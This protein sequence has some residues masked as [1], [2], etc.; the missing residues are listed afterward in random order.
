VKSRQPET[1]GDDDAFALLVMAAAD[2][3]RFK[4]QLTAIL[5]LP[6]FHRRSL[7]NT[8]LQE[9]QMKQA[10]PALIRAVRFLLDDAVAAKALEILGETFGD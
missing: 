6:S 8:L 4:D 7:L 5:T 9:M 10:R 1:V 2:D 3:R